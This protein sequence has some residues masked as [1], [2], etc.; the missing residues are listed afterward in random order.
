MFGKA[1]IKNTIHATGDRFV[2]GLERE[3]L[4][5]RTIDRDCTL[6]KRLEIRTIL[7]EHTHSFHEKGLLCYCTC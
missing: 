1:K 7:A 6:L 4:A 3:D 5:V 2:Q